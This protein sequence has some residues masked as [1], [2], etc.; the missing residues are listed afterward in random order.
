[1]AQIPNNTNINDVI[2]ASVKQLKDSTNIIKIILGELKNVSVIVPSD[3]KE[4]SDKLSMVNKV[5]TDYIGLL[6]KLS[7]LSKLDIN[8]INSSYKKLSYMHSYINDLSSLLSNVYS[9]Y[10]KFNEYKDIDKYIKNAEVAINAILNTLNLKPV[11]IGGMIGIRVALLEYRLI[12]SKILEINDLISSKY[13]DVQ[14][15]NQYATIIDNIYNI[16]SSIDAV[17]ANILLSA[18]VKMN[19]LN[20]IVDG[21]IVSISNINKKLSQKT[22]SKNIDTAI[23]SSQSLISITDSLVLM[24]NNLKKINGHV[25]VMQMTVKSIGLLI[26]VI[27]MLKD[28]SKKISLIKLDNRKIDNIVEFT[29]Q[30]VK[31]EKQVILLGI[32]SIPFAAAAI[33]SLVFITIGMLAIQAMMQ[34]ILYTTNPIIIRAVSISIRRLA[35]TM[36]MIAMTIASLALTIAVIVAAHEMIIGNLKQI[37]STIL[38]IGFILV[39]VIGLGW[40]MTISSPLILA[41]VSGMV[42]VGLTLLAIMGISM[43]LKEIPKYGF[44]D[45][46]QEAIKGAVNSIIS[47]VYSVVDSIFSAFDKPMGQKGEDGLVLSVSSLIL[48]DMF[49][50]VIKLVMSS[51]ILIFT[52]LSTGLIY[53]TSKVLTLLITDSSIQKVIDN[54]ETIKT[55]VRDILG[56]AKSVINSIFETFDSPI[57]DQHD[58]LLIGL[59]SWLL[60]DTFTNMVKLI[61]SCAALTFTTIAVSLIKLTAMSLN[62]ISEIKFDQSTVVS[63]TQTIM[64]TARSV[65]AAINAPVD[66]IYSGEKSKGR[67]LIEWLL[68]SGLM[69]MI[70]SIMAIGSLVPTLIAVGAVRFLAESINTISS[71]TIDTNVEK[72]AQDIVLMGSKLVKLINNQDSFG[73]M[74]NAKAIKRISILKD[75][76]D[77]LANFSKDVK[78]QDH[79]KLMDSTIKFL[80]K[81][82]TVKL[83]NL[84][85]AH[86]MFKEMK[87]FSQSISGNFEGLA[88]ALNEK[89]A[90]L[91]EEL[92]E[93]IGEI[94]KAVNESASTVSGSVHSAAAWSGGT[95]TQSQVAEQVARENPNMSKEDI[96]KIVDQRMVEQSQTVNKGIEMKLEELMEVLQNYSNPMPVRLT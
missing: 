59:S 18:Y 89:I 75:L 29:K 47:T 1:M 83:E 76:G 21:I 49:T 78:V 84:K 73:I 58:G 93:L 50:N 8:E 65:I 62:M 38:C 10:N 5:M 25:L 61:L 77:V 15:S 37:L 16:I 42:F 95:A 85:T 32:L 6:Q 20:N 80:D 45:K 33:L 57:S 91:L 92:K 3:I 48:G 2:R 22:L 87:E 46:Q 70:D 9:V 64:S 4:Y 74:D 68:P 86:N 44:D 14:N 72:K 12:L 51:S 11:G 52:I 24:L 17:S 79:E 23:S 28:L 27:D 67:E 43:I 96:N 88:D 60:G 39:A 94:P 34:L 69:N 19:L 56:T 26:H 30:I 66:P 54:G 35:L 36:L 63:N 7:G 41:A 53:L 55:N 81:I 90:P 40:L 82:N 71:V 31:I 13:K